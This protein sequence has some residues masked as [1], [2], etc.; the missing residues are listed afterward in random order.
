MKM[1]IWSVVM[2]LAQGPLFTV[3]WN[4]FCPTPRPVMDVFGLL[5]L[6]MVPVPLTKVQVP[7][8]GTMMELPAMVVV[9]L[10][11]HKEMSGPA[12]AFGLPAL[13]TRMRTRS[14]V[15]PFG[16]GPLLTDH[17]NSLIPT[18][19]PVMVVVGLFGFVMVPPPLTSVHVPTAGA[20]TLLAAMVT[21]LGATGTQIL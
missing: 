12:F 18:G 19:K 6:T 5:G 14:F 21:M 7:T 2:P 4:M 20:M 13:K 10:V 1:L 8:A 15:S 16:H 3:H 11:V 17:R 9:P